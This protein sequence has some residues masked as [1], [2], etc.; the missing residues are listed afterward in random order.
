MNIEGGQIFNVGFESIPK[1]SVLN[2]HS[3]C[4]QYGM[5]CDEND[6]IP[7]NMIPQCKEFHRKLIRTR[8][9]DAKRLG[10]PFILPEFG[11]CNDK[12]NCALEI[13]ALTEAADE[14]L[15]GW[16]YWAFKYFDDPTTI[17][18]NYLEGLFYENGTVQHDK[19]SELTRTSMQRTQGTLISQ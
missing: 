15:I 13:R 5:F 4:C 7:L 6:E 2:D 9:D 19:I 12:I 18:G 11:A 10:T 14:S 1:G 8:V 3:Y 16:A 17:V